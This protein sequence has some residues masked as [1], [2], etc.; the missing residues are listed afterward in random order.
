M[1]GRTASADADAYDPLPTSA[2]CRKG[3]NSAACR[4]GQNTV[5]TWIWHRLTSIQNNS[6]LPQGRGFC[7]AVG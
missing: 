7:S 4:K 2:A 1:D 3:Q 5:S 6:G